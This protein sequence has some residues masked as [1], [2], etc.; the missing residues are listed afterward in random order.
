MNFESIYHKPSSN[1]CFPLDNK[2]VVLRLRVSKKDNF[3]NIKVI[4]EGKYLF[5]YNQKEKEMYKQYEDKMFIYYEIKIKLED[6]RFVYVFLLIHNKKTYYYSEDGVTTSYDFKNAHYNCFQYAYINE[7]DVHKEV[8]W[9]KNSVFYEIFVDRFNSSNLNK[10]YI[11][12]KWGESVSSK[13]FA[14]GDLNGIIEK[15]DYLERVGVNTLYLTPIFSSIS[16]HKYDI[17]NYYEI[18]SQFGDK[19]TFKEL[20]YKAHKKRMY[21]V[22]DGVF[23]HTSDLLSEFQD[24]IKNGIKSKF[25]NWFIIKGDFV[26]TVNINYETF[27]NCY[28][29]PKFNTSNKEVQEYLINI[30]AYYVKEY[31]IDGWRLDVSDEASHDFWRNFRTQIKKIKKECFLVG[32]NWHDASPFLQGDQFDSIMNYAFTKALLD[33]VAYENYDAKDISEQLNML[34]IRYTTQVNNMMLNLLDSHDTDRFYTMVNKNKDKLLCATALTF[35]YVGIPCLYYGIEIPLEGGYDPD[36]RRCFLWTELDENSLYFKKLTEII[37]LR[38]ITT[39]KQGDIHIYSKNNLLYISRLDENYSYTLILNLSKK[40][41]SFEEKGSVV[42]IHKAN[43]FYIESN[44][45][46]VIKEKL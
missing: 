18:D 44:G 11:N 14:G 27:S 6:V 15:L 43:D 42:I 26:D 37:Y 24:V 13:S 46:V 33:Y 39:I 45:F 9:L 23:N 1:Y 19:K 34:L 20:V 35:M 32:E 36:N 10:S 25:F 41:C 21:V 3:E 28:Y 40:N 38:K 2:T 8:D 31:D 22:I 5:Y 29:H 17:N 7:I 12:T 16:N 30:G 4:Y